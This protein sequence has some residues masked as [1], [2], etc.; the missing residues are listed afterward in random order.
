MANVE[1]M[2]TED[3]RSTIAVGLT[4]YDNEGKKVGTV[5]D[6]DRVTGYAMI[7]SNPFSGRDLYVPFSLIT[8][9]D[10][11]DLFLSRSKEELKSNY[12]NPPARSTL[13]EDFDGKE[14][15]T[16]TEASGYDGTPLIVEQAKIDHLKKHIKIGGHV[17]SSDMADIGKIKQYDPATGWMMVEKG[18]LSSKRDLLIPVTL[19]EQVD[20]DSHDVYL[21]YS[22]ADLQQ[23]QQ[24]EPANVVFV[25]A[26]VAD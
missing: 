21:V 10:P 6:V 20:K 24:L 26:E 1:G 13:V 19:A 23:M 8:N 22:Q 11:H 14:T 16:T 18:V 12:A 15:A 3:I 17:Y 7:Q 4:A 9:I 25:E 2:I 5:D